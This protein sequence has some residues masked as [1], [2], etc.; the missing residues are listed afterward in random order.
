MFSLSSRALVSEKREFL[1]FSAELCTQVRRSLGG[2]AFLQ[3]CSVVLEGI[4]C[5][6]DI[7]SICV[8]C[9]KTLVF[10]LEKDLNTTDCVEKEEL[11]TD[12]LHSRRSLV[13]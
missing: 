1:G 5:L 4:T 6:F 7:F 8:S 13:E 9:S 10:C 11:L 12:F 2:L 3:D